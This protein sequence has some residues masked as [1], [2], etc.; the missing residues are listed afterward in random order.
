MNKLVYKPVSLAIS[1]TAGALSGMVFRHVW[2]LVSNE[3]EAPKPTSRD[4]GW[5]EIL[6]AAA[7]QG[8]IF[9]VVKAA[10]DRGGAH[11]VRKLTGEWP[12]D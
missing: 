8:A 5:G 11:G 2:K 7:L 6:A 3:D 10:I 12:D 9:A 4:Y 1:M